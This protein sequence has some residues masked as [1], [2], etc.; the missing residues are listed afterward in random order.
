LSTSLVG[1][2]RLES[3]TEPVKLEIEGD[4]GYLMLA[5]VE[6]RDIKDDVMLPKG[7]MG[8][9]LKKLFAEDKEVCKSACPVP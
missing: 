1:L 6:T 4:T 9:E 5:D 8:E 7:E 2:A 3:L